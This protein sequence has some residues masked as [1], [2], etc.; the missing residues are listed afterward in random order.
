[1][2]DSKL[3]TFS[4]CRKIYK[5]IILGYSKDSSG[6]IYVKHFRETD[7]GEINEIKQ[8]IISEC[9]DKGLLSFS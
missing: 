3:E 7:I 1:M 4:D 2:G 5:D 8:H 9:K 6:N